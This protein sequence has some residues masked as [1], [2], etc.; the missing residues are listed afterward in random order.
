MLWYTTGFK[1]RFRI[2]KN[3]INTGKVKGR[4]VKWQKNFLIFVAILLVNLSTYRK[5][6]TT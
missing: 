3:D 1:E 4:V 6:L 5:Y 2:H